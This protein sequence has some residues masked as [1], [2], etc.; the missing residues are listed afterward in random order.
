MD[1]GIDW[2]S[3]D[4]QKRKLLLLLSKVGQQTKMS[5]E[6]LKAWEADLLAKL[7]DQKQNWNNLRIPEVWKQLEEELHHSRV[8]SFLSLW[9]IVNVLNS[10]KSADHRAIRS[11]QLPM[12][13]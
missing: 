10:V 1:P 3:K 11:S 6:M 13:G 9:P 5:A 12:H 4:A 8:S 2:L 7:I